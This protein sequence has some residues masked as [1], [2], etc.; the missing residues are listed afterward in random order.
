MGSGLRSRRRAAYAAAMAVT[1]DTVE[2]LRSYALFSE[3]TD[4]QLRVIGGKFREV[5]YPAGYVLCRQGARGQ[6]FFVLESGAAEVERD[7]KLVSTLGPGNFFGE[8]A[9][10]DDGPRTATV[11]ART[12]IRCLVLEPRDFFDV[13]GQNADIAIQVLRAVTQRLRA[14]LELQS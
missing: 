4:D 2:R 14:L 12:P 8:I 3:C 5:E 1:A 6:A 7:G 13:L 11:V 9:L 10:I